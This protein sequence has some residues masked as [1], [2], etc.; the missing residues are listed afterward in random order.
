[1]EAET[2]GTEVRLMAW[3]W[4]NNESELIL[5]DRDGNW[6]HVPVVLGARLGKPMSQAEASAL[7]REIDDDQNA[8]FLVSFER[9]QYVRVE[10]LAQLIG[11]PSEGI[12]S[13][14]LALMSTFGGLPSVLR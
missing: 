9:S 13:D 2:L 11:E 4:R 3:V 14:D 5:Q 8:T 1:M 6:Y 10:E 12:G 7:R